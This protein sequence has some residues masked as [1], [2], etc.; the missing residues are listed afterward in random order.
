MPRPRG[1]GKG[2]TARINIRL[3]QETEAFYKRKANE[4]GVS[5]SQFLRDT[6]IQGIV[7]EGVIEID[8]RLQRKIDAAMEAADKLIQQRTMHVMLERAVLESH[9]LLEKIVESQDVQ[10]LYRAQEIAKKRFQQMRDGS[11]KTA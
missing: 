5:L 6:L 9:A 10:A 3:D 11:R 8:A 1:S 7:A 2:E 4:S